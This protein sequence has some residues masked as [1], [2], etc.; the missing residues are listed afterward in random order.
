MPALKT[1]DFHAKIL[2][3]GRVPLEGDGL[4]SEPV[5]ALDLRFEGAV[6]ERHSGLTRP[7]CSRVLSQHQRGTEIRNVRQLAIVSA[8]ELAAIAERMGLARIEPEWIGASMVVEGLPDFSHIPPSSRLQGP[9][10]TTLAV[11]MENRPCVL[12]GREIE[13]ERDGFGARFKPAADGRRGVTA[14]VER[15]GRLA[16]GETLQLSIPDQRVW[17]H[18][19][20][21]RSR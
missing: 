11:D 10:G 6:G 16:V 8:E 20:A 14:W 3:L 17:A 1:T 9:D 19:E 13:I 4:R 12:P 21:V 5:E 18:I 15:P 7:S 2:W